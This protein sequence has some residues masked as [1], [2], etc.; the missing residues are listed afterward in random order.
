[1]FDALRSTVRELGWT[2]SVL[3]WLSRVLHRA[4]GGRVRLLRYLLVAQPIGDNDLTPGH[5]GRGIEVI[6]AD[7][8]S[9]LVTD[10]GRPAAV[11]AERLR[12]GSRCLLA[13]K[14]GRLVGFQWF[15]TG[16]YPED[17]VRCLFELRP[18]D[19][20]AWD[21]DIFV[22]PEA[23]TQPVFLRLWDG[24]NARLRADGVSLSLSRINA[25][26]AASVRAHARMGARTLATAVFVTIGAWQLA[27]LPG[28]LR[29]HLSR[30]ATPRLPISRIARQRQRST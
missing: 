24:C 16:H 9:I 14:D 17:E 6:E 4:S 10:F 5:R 19:H 30:R 3:Y 18:E 23:R 8:H 1:L 25:F 28:R 2:N 15:T 11:I 26:N 21:F 29:P 27:L 20:C 22:K 12:I 13:H 7:H